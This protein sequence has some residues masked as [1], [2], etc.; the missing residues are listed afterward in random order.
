MSLTT[1]RKRSA[2]AEPDAKAKPQKKPRVNK[3]AQESAVEEKPSSFVMPLY[4][5]LSHVI[6]TEDED[7][8]V[9]SG[10]EG[11]TDEEIKEESTD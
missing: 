1:G 10:N 5:D 7:T 11:G 4:V 8:I 9:E 2:A 3:K 6:K